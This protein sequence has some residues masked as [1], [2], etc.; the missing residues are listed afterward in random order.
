MLLAVL[1][2]LLLLVLLLLALLHPLL[3][4]C[5]GEFVCTGSR[6]SRVSLVTLSLLSPGEMAVGPSGIRARGGG[7]KAAGGAWPAECCAGRGMEGSVLHGS[8][9]V[10]PCNAGVRVPLALQPRHL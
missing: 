1:L 4:G 5:C 3:L 8:P 2:A 10:H 9:C 7:C 6:R